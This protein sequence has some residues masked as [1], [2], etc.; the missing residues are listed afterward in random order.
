[1]RQHPPETAADLERR[2]ICNRSRGNR[3]G[4]VRTFVPP[5]T[6]HQINGALLSEYPFR[7]TCGVKAHAQGIG[8]DRSRMAAVNVDCL[9]GVDPRSLDSI[10][11]DGASAQGHQPPVW[12]MKRL[13]LPATFWR[14]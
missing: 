9:E 11:T 6:F 7:P 3:L 14:E 8:P 4:A 12:L 10:A 13:T 5:E 1:M 2:F